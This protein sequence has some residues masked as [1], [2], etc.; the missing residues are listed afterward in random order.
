M[1]SRGA[2]LS[3]AQ[4]EAHLAEA[5]AYL[6]ES[7]GVTDEDLQGLKGMIRGGRIWY[8]SLDAWPMDHWAEGSWRPISV[9]FRAVETDTRGRFRPTNDLL[10][11]LGAAVRRGAVDVDVDGLSTLLRREPLPSPEGVRG[12]V[13][14]RFEKE[15]LGRALA[16]DSGMRSEIPK[17]RAA[18][19][20]QVMERSGVLEEPGPEA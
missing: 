11:W 7:F 6:A 4:A 5:R 20:R 15:I 1:V 14:V 12:M 3:P 16:L 8:H 17:A 10:T 13:A 9:G 2:G 19:L 18:D